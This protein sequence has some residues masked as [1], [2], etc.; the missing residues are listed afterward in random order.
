MN[1]HS[2]LIYKAKIAEQTERFDDMVKL[3]KELI[4][5]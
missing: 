1:Q 2:D 4:E 3:M 5:K